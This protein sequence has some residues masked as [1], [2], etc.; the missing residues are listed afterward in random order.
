M[1]ALI[2]LVCALSSAALAQT[3]QRYAGSAACK[4][5]HPAIYARW[6]R[7]RMANVVRDPRTHPDAIIPD[8]SK[9]DPLVKFTKDDIAFVYGSKW[10]QRYFTKKGDDYYP[11]GAQ[12]DVTHQVWRPYQVAPGTDWWTAHYL[13]QRQYAAPHR[14]ALRRLP[15][16]Q[17]RHLNQ[18]RD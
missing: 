2:L 4:T 15:L 8:L 18:D 10:K 5:C 1:H 3:P 7:T 16:C 11:L 13:S 17:L 14:S 9:P 12:W 6:S